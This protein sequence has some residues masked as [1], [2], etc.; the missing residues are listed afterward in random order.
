M[1]RLPQQTM[2]NLQT[3][4]GIRSQLEN[5]TNAL[6]FEQDR[7]N[8]IDRQMQQMREGALSAPMGTSGIPST[9]RQRVIA[10][11]REL[12][13]ARVK[14]K[15]TH[16]EIQ[17][18]EEELAT[19][20]AEAKAFSEQSD[21]TRAEM[22]AAD[23]AYQQIAEERTELQLRIRQ[24][25]RS[26]T[27]L[28]GDIARYQQRVE[29]APMVEQEL[30]SLQRDYDFEREN[31]KQ[32]SERHTA[33]LLQEQVARTRGGE[34]FSVLSGAY[35]PQSP[36][37]PKRLRLALI[38]LALGIGLGGALVFGR[39]YVDWSIRDPRVLQD[40]FDVPVLAEIPRI[41]DAA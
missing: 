22:L 34:R 6:R 27:Q 15:D 8:A 21:D 9:P 38:A 7:L 19:A 25:R 5:T 17:F 26:Q 41:R 12:Q 33:A 40:Q 36:E 13:L 4:T 24:L 20:R 16:P 10:L 31:F 14:Y 39:E 30:A 2:A 29:S 28:Q 37:S 1:G 23:P 35:L 32:L 11:Q 18:L 3:L